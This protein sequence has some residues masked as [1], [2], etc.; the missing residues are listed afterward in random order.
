MKFSDIETGVEF[1]KFFEPSPNFL[2]IVQYFYDFIKKGH[3]FSGEQGKC[4][5][6]SSLFQGQTLQFLELIL[7]S[8]G[9]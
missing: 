8:I 5:M 7:R 3:A 2:R 9:R 6:D 4:R 1:S